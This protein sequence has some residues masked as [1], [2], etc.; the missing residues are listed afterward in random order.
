VKCSLDGRVIHDLKSSVT[1]TPRLF[2]SATWDANRNEA[3]IKVVNTAAEPT[4]TEINLKGIKQIVGEAH[5]I[6][7]TSADPRDENTLDEPLKVS[8]KSQ[9]LKIAG[10]KFTHSFAGNSLTVVR[11]KP[12]HTP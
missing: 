4:E 1:T 3:I 8:P 2:A 11:V 10:P 7:L 6:V 5:A 12:S 9:S